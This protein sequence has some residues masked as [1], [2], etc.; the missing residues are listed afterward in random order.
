MISPM[1]AYRY[2]RLF[3]VLLAL[4]TLALPIA[5]AQTPRDDLISEL[6]A[7]RAAG[8]SDE[9]LAFNLFLSEYRPIMPNPLDDFDLIT[10]EEL[11][12]QL[13]EEDA[14]LSQFIADLAS[15]NCD[16]VLANLDHALNLPSLLLAIFYDEGICLPQNKAVAFELYIALAQQF[17]DPIAA[18]RLGNLYLTDQEGGPNPELADI[19]FTKA[20]IW[21]AAMILWADQQALGMEEDSAEYRHTGVTLPKT[22]AGFSVLETGAWELPKQLSEKIDWLRDMT[23]GDTAEFIAF[24]EMMRF[25]ETGHFYDPRSAVDWALMG[26]ELF[27]SPEL[28][29]KSG[30][31]SRDRQYC[32][33]LLLPNGG[34]TC[35]F[36]FQQGLNDIEQAAAV[37][38][39]EAIGY[40]LTYLSENSATP[41]RSWRL[42][43]FLILA[44]RVGVKFDQALR[45]EIN[46]EPIEVDV[47][48]AWLD[49]PNPLPIVA[50]LVPFG[51]STE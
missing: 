25:D 7:A 34:S 35:Q 31:W 51:A 33:Y 4:G 28:L 3:L 12:R 17:R 41:W 36:L 21:Q 19:W 44:E 2:M 43:Q 39:A 18:A 46:L 1:F 23:R 11:D 6:E 22:R 49:R 45:A 8:A 50:Y 14:Q 26:S 32:P 5:D 47:I 40:M 16:A 10:D 38:E 37:G 9:D 29:F 27:S 13:A 15:E 48:H 24:V 20:V 42:F 30:V